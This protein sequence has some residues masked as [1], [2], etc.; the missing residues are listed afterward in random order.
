MPRADI[1]DIS[2]YQSTRGG[3]DCFKQWLSWQVST[4]FNCSRMSDAPM[5][6]TGKEHFTASAIIIENTNVS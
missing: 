2:L 5:K 6:R 3:T 4:S 1:A